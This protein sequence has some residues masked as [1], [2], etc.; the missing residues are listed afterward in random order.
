MKVIAVFTGTRA[1]YGL[2]RSL[3]IRIDKDDEFALKLLV[4]STHLDPKFGKTIN[5]INS[6][7][8]SSKYLIPIEINPL[9]KFDMNLQL[10]ETIVG[11]SKALDEVNP[12][13]LIVLGDRYETLG[14]VLSANLMRINVIHLHG[15]EQT[16]GALDDKF[17]HAISHLSSIHFTSAELHKN[18]VKAIIGNS[19]N[20]YNVGPMAIDGILNSKIITKEEF[21]QK[22]GFKF[23]KN[24]FLVTYHS[25]TLASDFGV[26]GFKNLLDALKN[27]NC[28]ILFTSPNADKGSEKIKKLI[29]TFVEEDLTKRCYIPSLGQELYLN[30]LMLF[31]C[32]LGNSSSGIIEAPIIGI[33]VLN[34]GDRQRGRFR[35]GQVIDVNNDRKLIQ[36]KIQEIILQNTNS[37][38]ND[39]NLQRDFSKLISPSK[40]IVD[41]LKRI[42]KP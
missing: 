5:E 26:G 4:S 39:L 15:G 41:I 19:N 6:D 32:V 16:L 17:R 1:E 8:L 14:A 38:E 33:K 12:D 11:V 25:E 2:M 34:I 22:T 28:N 27:F 20:I 29:D 13:Y 23:G 35:F 24:N 37:K 36:K 42:D 10:S 3:I 31:D 21:N 9:R 7:E 18:K 30:A 40:L